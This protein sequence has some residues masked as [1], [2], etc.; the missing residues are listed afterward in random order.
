MINSITNRDCLVAILTYNN[1]DSLEKTLIRIPNDYEFD[2]LVHVDGSTDSSDR[3]LKYYRY[4]VIY[5]KKNGGL[6]KS[7]RNVIEFAKKNDYKVLM[8]IPG[9]NK[10]DPNEVDRMLSPILEKDVDFVQGSR[11]L[12]DSRNDNTPVFRI[13]IVKLYSL[14]FSI[15][16][17]KKITDALEGFRAYKLSIFD[18]PK[19]DIYQEW[20]DTYGLE[21]Y[22]FYKILMSNNYKYCEVPVSK[23][24]PVNKKHL[25]N[26]KGEKYSHIRPLVDWWH[27]IKPVFYLFFKIK[28]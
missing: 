20:L 11:F 10:N 14:F 17:R 1:G 3:I 27:I 5:Q 21:T 2:V 25:L 18:N 8:V 16:A 22:I 23:I 4:K 9:N 12:K 24:Y 13:I 7:L 28:K 15:L 19:I 6:G 26:K